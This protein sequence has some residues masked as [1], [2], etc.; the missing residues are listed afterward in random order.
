MDGR[1][2]VAVL[3]ITSAEE[4]AEVLPRVQDE[5]G[6]RLPGATPLQV[7]VQHRQ[8]WWNLSDDLS[9]FFAWIIETGAGS[10]DE[11]RAFAA[12]PLSRPDWLFEAAWQMTKLLD[13]ATEV[14][15]NEQ[16]TYQE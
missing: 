9:Q 12:A 3:D 4:L 6:D 10:L 8:A 16:Q 2:E 15:S 14:H 1:T 13:V 5:V 7:H 11:T